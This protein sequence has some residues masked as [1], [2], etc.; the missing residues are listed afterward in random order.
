MLRVQEPAGSR[1][2]PKISTNSSNRPLTLTLSLG[3]RGKKITIIH[4]APSLD[5]GKR[6]QPVRLGVR[7][8]EDVHDL[9][10]ARQQRIGDHLAVTSPRNG[11]CAP[12][13]HGVA[14]CV[15]QQLLN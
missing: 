3:E 1:L 4:E 11:L 14:L 5:S 2:N 8:V 6:G 15:A 13:R 7:P 9:H 10:A 12:Y